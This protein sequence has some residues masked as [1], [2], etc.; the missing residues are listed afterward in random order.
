MTGA[1]R[2]PHILGSLGVHHH[3]IRATTGP[4]VT[5]RTSARPQSAK[6][7]PCIDQRCPTFF[8]NWPA[9]DELRP[10]LAWGRPSLALIRS[11]ADD[12]ALGAA[13]GPHDVFH[14]VH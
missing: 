6:L 11:T 2:G 7:W 12:G 14:R 10:K 13:S 3:E 1:V 8:R 5:H 9:L 4:Q